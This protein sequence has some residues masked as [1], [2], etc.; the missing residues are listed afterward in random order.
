MP[1]TWPMHHM[2]GRNKE[3]IEISDK[4]RADLTVSLAALLLFARKSTRDPDQTEGGPL[5][6]KAGC[7]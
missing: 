2:I 5:S 4:V 7:P 1:T 3:L 6:E